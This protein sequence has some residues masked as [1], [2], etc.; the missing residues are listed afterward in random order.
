M[1]NPTNQ[2]TISVG[3]RVAD[4]SHGGL[5]NKISSSSSESSFTLDATGC[6][7]CGRCADCG[8]CA[9]R[10]GCARCVGCAVVPVASVP[11]SVPA[12]TVVRI[13]WSAPA[14][15]RSWVGGGAGG[16]GGA[17]VVMTRPLSPCP[18]A[19][20]KRDSVCVCA[21]GRARVCL[22][23]Y[24]RLDLSNSRKNTYHTHTHTHPHTHD[25][26]T[27]TPK[28]APRVSPKH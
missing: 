28:E 11:A 21:R 19:W 23:M 3:L 24:E 7:D 20:H 9:E 13:I 18:G 26:H 4:P 25:T 2:S 10:G 8:G 15:V 12:S 17:G 14:L 6:A 1:S 16:A 27:H 5:P 22:C